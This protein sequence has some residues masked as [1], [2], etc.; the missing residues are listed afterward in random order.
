VGVVVDSIPRRKRFVST[1]RSR[2]ASTSRRWW[3][4]REVARTTGPVITRPLDPSMRIHS[5]SRIRH[6][7]GEVYKAYSDDLPKLVP[8]IPDIKDIVVKSREATPYGKKIWNR[9]IAGAD[10]PTVVQSV[11]KPEML[12]W[13]DF[14]EWHDAETYVDWRLSFPAFPNRV[15]CGGRNAFIGDGDQTRVV[16]TGTL[17][18][19]LKDF[20]GIPSLVARRVGPKVEEFIVK[21]ITPNL[22]RVNRSLQ[23]YLDDQV[24]QDKTR[25]KKG[26]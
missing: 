16:L 24:A 11:I 14:A 3:G 4:P 2:S 22:E 21:L 23:Q 1:S 25:A 17:E 20:P 7:L 19:D 13:D 15:K 9:W 10:L 5:E 12:Q 18:I 26:A 8:Y 6:P